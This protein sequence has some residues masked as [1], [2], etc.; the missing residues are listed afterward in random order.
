MDKLKKKRSKKRS[1]KKLGEEQARFIAKTLTN[2]MEEA[3]KRIMSSNG[4]TMFLNT[5]SSLRTASKK[6]IKDKLRKR[7]EE[8]KKKV[9]EGS[10]N[11]FTKAEASYTK[12]DIRIEA[13]NIK[14]AGLDGPKRTGPIKTQIPANAKGL[15]NMVQSEKGKDVVKE[16]FG[17]T[18]M[19]DGNPI[20][21]KCSYNSK[22][23]SLKRSEE[24]KKALFNLTTEGDSIRAQY[25]TNL[26]NNPDLKN[27]MD[28]LVNVRR[29]LP[30]K[31]LFGPKEQ[32]L[33][34]EIRAVHSQIKNANKN[35]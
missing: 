3:S 15:L 4:V 9:A 34:D 12:K 16:R 24:S 19:P 31:D 8:A 26:E 13:R 17:Y 1:N 10:N 5:K 18:Q 14:R 6:E 22:R 35:K 28:S 29:N 25:K 7:T 32:K 11:D 20:T 27:K 33:D 23:S 21:R 2:P 30:A